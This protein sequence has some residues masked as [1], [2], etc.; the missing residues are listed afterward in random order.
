MSPP[1]SLAQ[2]DVSRQ[3]LSPIVLGITDRQ[4]PVRL[5]FLLKEA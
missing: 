5:R 4:R 3:L 2:W 1:K